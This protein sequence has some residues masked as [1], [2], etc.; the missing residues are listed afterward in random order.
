MVN[1]VREIRKARH[2]D[3]MFTIAMRFFAMAVMTLL[4]LIIATLVIEAYPAMKAFGIRFLVNEQWNVGL[5]KFGAFSAI[6]GTIITS[7][8]AIVIALPI[9]FG[10]AI[11]LTELSPECLKRPIGFAIELLAG[12]PSIIYGIWGLFVFAPFF[13]RYVLQP[14]NLGNLGLGYFTA[15]FILSLMIIPFISS[16]MRDIFATIP[17]MLKE[18][19]YGLGAT[20]WEVVR[21]IFIPNTLHG[22]VGAIVLGLGRALGETMAVT[23]VIGS[24]WGVSLNIFKPGQS[25]TSALA[26][27][28]SEAEGLQ[29]A[30][31]M[32]L[33][34]VLMG[35]SLL[36]LSLSKYLLAKRKKY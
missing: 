13:S 9:S 30:A 20:R 31:L 25:I 7:L 19:A 26:N 5:E 8:I 18:S 12:I 1:L 21:H 4:L 35:I 32:Y 23:F 28:F 34:V 2:L 33:S 29:M 16:V 15:G 22:M 11:F 10:I 27:E 36:I 3:R 6:Y 17:Q 14:L 24:T